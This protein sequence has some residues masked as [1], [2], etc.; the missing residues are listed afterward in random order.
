[1]LLYVNTVTGEEAVA[2]LEER[3]VD[4]VISDLRMPGQLD[5]LDL[6]VWV[7][8]HRPK[9]VRRFLF[10]SGDLSAFAPGCEADQHNIPRLQK[11][12]TFDGLAFDVHELME[13]KRRD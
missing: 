1:M 12:F 4:L 13:E 7:C 2:V 6:F 8:Q 11:P 9:L 10:V 5:G 3:E